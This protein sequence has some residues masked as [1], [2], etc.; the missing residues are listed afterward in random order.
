MSDWYPKR[1]ADLPPWHANLKTETAAN[2]TTVGLSAGQVTQISDDSVTVAQT[3]NYAEAVDAFRQEVTAYKEAVLRGDPLAAMPTAPVA[4]A[5]LAPGLAA[6]P[7]IEARTRDLMGIVK[8]ST[9][10]TTAIGEAYQIIAP[11]P[12]GFGTP[13][14]AAF[15]LTASQV[16]LKIGKAGYSVLAVDSRLAGGDWEQI[17]VSMKAEFIDTRPPVT[18][19]QPEKREYR[20]QGMEDN[21]RTGAMSDVST[22]VTVP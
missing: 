22:A 15:A 21:A 6:L 19:G 8:A 18:P 20:V 10:Y 9:A 2:G 14:V 11:V 3:V 12:G 7:G 4:P 17:G 1:Q 13:T 16:R 5:T